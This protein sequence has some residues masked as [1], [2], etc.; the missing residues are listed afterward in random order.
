MVQFVKLDKDATMPQRATYQ[1]AG[2]DLHALNDVHI[3][4]GTRV[5]VPT[6]ISWDTME[7]ESAV[8]LIRPRSGLAYKKGIMVMAGVIDAD[9]RGDIGVVLFNSSPNNLEF[10]AGSKIAQLII[11][12]FYLAK[13]DEAVKE[14]IARDGG[15]GSTGK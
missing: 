6:G 9:Y 2:Y 5:L 12:R 7:E 11:M 15:F 14:K 4:A 8:G 13:D 10:D 3:A 1:S